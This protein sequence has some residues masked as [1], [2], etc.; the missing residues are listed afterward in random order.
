MPEIMARGVGRV[1]QNSVSEEVWESIAK[2]E[3]QENKASSSV[4]ERALASRVERN[5]L[6]L[7]NLP[8]SHHF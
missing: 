8:L 6:K 1:A 7:P 4:V 3:Q 5:R 2:V